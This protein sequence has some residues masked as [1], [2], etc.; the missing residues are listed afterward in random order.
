MFSVTNLAGLGDGNKWGDELDF[1]DTFTACLL[2]DHTWVIIDA[3]DVGRWMSDKRMKRTWLQGGCP[4]SHVNTAIDIK[5]KRRGKG[6]AH[7]WFGVTP[8]F[9]HIAAHH[10]VVRG[11][12]D[13]IADCKAFIAGGTRSKR[14]LF[15]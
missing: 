11:D 6:V 14:R 13:D 10:K 1:A 2:D 9:I 12:K 8:P 3:C 4:D 5:G 15:R 7:E